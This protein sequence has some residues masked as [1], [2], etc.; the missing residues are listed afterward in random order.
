MLT[1]YESWDL[2]LPLMPPRSRLYQI[3]PVGIGTLLIESL[4]SYLAR[5]AEAHCL[6]PGVLMERELAPILNKTYG[7]TNLHKISNFTG[8]L[9]GTGVMATDLSKTIQTLTLRND[10]QFLTL[11]TWSELLTS[12]NL[13]RS[14]RF[15]C[16]AC[17]EEWYTTSQV[18]YEP[19]LWSLDVVKVCPHHKQKLSQKCF[20]CCQTNYTL[21]WRSRP[22]YCSKCGEWLGLQIDIEL[23]DRKVSSEA[24]LEFEIWMAFA[25]GELLAHAPS[26]NFPLSKDSIA[27]ALCAYANQATE[28]NIAAFARQLQIPRNTLWLW[29]KGESIPSIK[30]LLQI[31]YCLKISVLDF[32]TQGVESASSLETMRLP[33]SQVATKARATS[34]VFDTNRVE[35]DLKAII[36]SN[37]SPPPSMEEVARRLNCDRRTIY[38]HFRHLCTTISGKYLTYRKASYLQ[39]IEECCK[40]IREIT[41]KL[42]NQNEYPTEARVSA[43]MSRPGFFRYKK[44]RSAL[45]KIRQELGL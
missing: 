7:S 13:L 33:P 42:H 23:C 8:A 39:T 21:A 17:Y 45:N 24:N 31:C 38:K 26:L 22:G 25:I 43:L 9:N 34:K 2:R 16:P 28:G 36:M 20:H 1:I 37:E 29:C 6:F 10:L 41:V 4:T 19:L 18:I 44:V 11:L 12:R 30:S 27:K 5:L 15:W 14:I 32:L 40:E 3:E 35:Q